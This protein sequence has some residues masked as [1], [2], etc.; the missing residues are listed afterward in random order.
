MITSFGRP[1]LL[2]ASRSEPMAT[3]LGQ[4]LNLFLGE[5]LPY[6][7][8][9][10]NASPIKCAED[11]HARLDALDRRSLFNA[12]CL[13]D[14][15]DGRSISDWCVTGH[16]TGVR[17]TELVLR[18]PEVYF[19][20]LVRTV[21]TKFHIETREAHFV[22][23]GDLTSLLRQLSR[24]ASGFRTYFDPTGLRRYLRRSRTDQ[25]EQ[26][27]NASRVAA[28]IDEEKDFL[29]TNGY[30]LYSYGYDT[31]LVPSL[32]EMEHLLGTGYT[33]KAFDIILEDIDLRFPDI[34]VSGTDGDAAHRGLTLGDGD[35]DRSRV[36]AA[37]DLRAKLFP[38]LGRLPKRQ[39]VC[40]STTAPVGNEHPS[41]PKPFGGFLHPTWEKHLAGEGR[42]IRRGLQVTEVRTP[43]GS[44][45]APFTRQM[46]ASAL[47]DRAREI[48]KTAVGQEE[49]IHGALLALDAWQ[50]LDGKTLAL[51]LEAL[52]ILYGFEVKAECAF[53]G[54]AQ[55]LKV[56][57]RFHELR[58]VVE[59]VVSKRNVKRRH[60]INN[61]MV[62]IADD[63]RRTYREYEQ[64]DEEEEALNWVRGYRVKLHKWWLQPFE[65]YFVSIIRSFRR[66]SM[67]CA[68]WI[69]LFSLLW[70]HFGSSYA[71]C[72][73]DDELCIRDFSEA[74][75]MSF[76]NFFAVDP[77]ALWKIF[78]IQTADVT[79]LWMYQ[80]AAFFQAFLG[81]VHLGILIAYL[82][83]K[84]SRR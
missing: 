57:R 39:R 40:V 54:T 14:L 69:I 16:E 82:Y 13:V 53:V 65:H 81:F 51:S 41:V 38:G 78:T 43:H 73:K 10:Q 52:D 2:V 72:C 49:A 56:G 44:H 76:T 31:A 58:A 61:A 6:R 74:F 25:L 15:T 8:S 23:I 83:Q 67:V 11:I 30:L 77:T 27:G 20:F 29:L 45:S 28:T 22:V 80:S 4:V 84:I 36:D 70:A 37:L 12:V 21:P 32:T 18:Y 35:G 50:L 48:R 55:S 59:T 7:L 42:G 9:D 75:E 47:T 66:I 64:F 1:T 17:P 62:E 71:S 24:H 19:I 3:A 26:Q 68:A 34:S 63:L 79:N 46:I 33:G 60:Q 5:H